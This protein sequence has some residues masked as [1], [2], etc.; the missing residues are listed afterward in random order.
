MKLMIKIWLK[1]VRRKRGEQ[2]LSGGI[3]HNH[4]KEE[5]KTIILRLPMAA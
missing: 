3:I 1:S 4:L 5:D 2:I